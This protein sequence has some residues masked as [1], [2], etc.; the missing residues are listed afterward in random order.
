[1]SKRVH[2]KR[3]DEESLVEL[4]RF[5]SSKWLRNRS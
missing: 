4:I 1:M 3:L 2:L 5:C